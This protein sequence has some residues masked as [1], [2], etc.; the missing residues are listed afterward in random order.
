MRPFSENPEAKWLPARHNLA[1]FRLLA[2]I[3]LTLQRKRPRR[4]AVDLR[5]A[6]V[7]DRHQSAL[8]NFTLALL[9]NTFITVYVGAWLQS[10][11]GLPPAR[12]FWLSPLLFVMAPAVYQ[13]LFHPLGLL[14][15]VLVRSGRVRTTQ[16]VRVQTW[17]F[18]LLMNGF[19]LVALRAGSWV[20]WAGMVW[21]ALLTANA[22]AAVVMLALSP[23]VKSL[24][25]RMGGGSF[26]VS[27]WDSAA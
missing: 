27:Y 16:V 22:A 7:L 21:L 18:Y 26:D 20:R 14:L 8:E 15:A 11:F 9:F 17:T 12:L 6:Y 23:F 3:V 19:A 4:P 2:A 5:T 25:E 24:E 13:L 1:A 10:G